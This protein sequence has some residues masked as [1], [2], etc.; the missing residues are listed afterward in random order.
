MKHKSA[1]GKSANTHTTTARRMKVVVEI[2]IHINEYLLYKEAKAFDKQ[3]SSNC[4][5]VTE[6]T[7]SDE[8]YE[9]FISN[10]LNVSSNHSIPIIQLFESNVFLL[11]ILHKQI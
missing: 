8:A 10:S 1:A 9:V 6:P 5:K 11:S 7:D 2:Y 3:K 4:L